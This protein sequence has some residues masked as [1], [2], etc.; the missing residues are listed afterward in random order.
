MRIFHTRVSGREYVNISH[1]RERECE[2]DSG[3]ENA[4]NSHTRECG[5]ERDYVNT[6][7]S[8]ESEL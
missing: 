7:H 5:C 2:C 4:K 3:N 6:S 1:M 8:R